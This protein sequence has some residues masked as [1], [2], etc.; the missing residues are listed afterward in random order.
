MQ[1]CAEE[2]KTK[3]SLEKAINEKKKNLADLDYVLEEEKRKVDSLILATREKED[4]IITSSDMDV[5]KRKAVAEKEEADTEEELESKRKENEKLGSTCKLLKNCLTWCQE[6]NQSIERILELMRTLDKAITDTNELRKEVLGKINEQNAAEMETN[7][8]LRSE[9]EVLAQDIEKQARIGNEARSKYEGL[10]K[11]V[12][13][14]IIAIIDKTK[15][16]REE[17][18]RISENIEKCNEQIKEVDVIFEREQ[19]ANEVKM[20]ELT[21]LLETSFKSILSSATF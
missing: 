4:Q 20:K 15:L 2:S 13:E 10:I 17:K 1:C 19:S 7:A 9:A 14:K 12:N 3:E 18:E 11:E 8:K 6:K 5:V 16:L 21:E